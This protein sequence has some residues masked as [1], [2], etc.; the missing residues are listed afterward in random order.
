MRTVLT[1]LLSYLRWIR[2]QRNERTSRDATD[3][4][5]A[6]TKTPRLLQSLR[7]GRC[8][9]Y[10]SC[11]CYVLPCERCVRCAQ[12]PLYSQ[13]LYTVATTSYWWTYPCV[14]DFEL[15]K[16][17][18]WHIVL[19]HRV[20]NIVLIARRPLTR[21]VLVALLLRI[22]IRYTLSIIISPHAW[23]IAIISKSGRTFSK[24]LTILLVHRL[25]SS[26]MSSKS[27]SNFLIFCTETDGPLWKHNL[28]GETISNKTIIWAFYFC[29]LI[30]SASVCVT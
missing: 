9:S 22:I 25:C 13:Q 20:D 14:G 17:I 29:G 6:T 3:I 24:N 5:D 7:F 10:V 15:S 16:N 18:L 27:I 23:I 1:Y 8:I 4:V 19:C 11:V 26:K 21:P 12:I 28:L 30:N 2:I